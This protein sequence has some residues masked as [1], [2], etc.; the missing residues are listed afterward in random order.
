MQVRSIYVMLS[1]TH[2]HFHRSF[3]IWRFEQLV[4]NPL[5]YHP[6]V[7]QV[8]LN[9]WNPQPNLVAVRVTASYR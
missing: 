2:E 7:N 3:T 8:E 9:Y 4:K 1:A 5:K 6:L